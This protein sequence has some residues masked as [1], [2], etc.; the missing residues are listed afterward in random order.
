MA[1]LLGESAGLSRIASLRRTAPPEAVLTQQN[2]AFALLAVIAG[3]LFPLQTSINAL[4]ARSV[5]GPIAATTISFMVG[6]VVL[7]LVDGVVFR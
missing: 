6:L 3:A 4:L 7:C 5:G 1:R 2:I